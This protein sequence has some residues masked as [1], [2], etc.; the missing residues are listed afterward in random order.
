MRGGG[1]A[2]R[3]L[4][5][6]HLGV[7]ML[8]HLGGRS[9]AVASAPWTA[10]RRVAPGRHRGAQ[11][12][13]ALHAP[14]DSAVGACVASA[15]DAVE[16]PYESEDEWLEPV[17]IVELEKPEPDLSPKFEDEDEDEDEGKVYAV[18]RGRVSRPHK[19]YTRPRNVARRDGVL[20]VEG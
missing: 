7:A 16:D 5:L 1:L 20:P 8:T 4:E 6:H 17:S 18:L 14:L 12:A 10:L 13:V 2:G 9:M 3:G 19:G 11:A 15:I